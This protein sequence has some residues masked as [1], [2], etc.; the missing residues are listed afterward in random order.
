MN[1]KILIFSKETR[2]GMETFFR[3]LN[4]L[5]NKNYDINFYFFKKDLLANYKGLTKTFINSNFPRDLGFTLEKVVIF[6]KN[7]YKSFNVIKNSEPD[8]IFAADIYS[9][10]IIS[11]VKI[12]SDKPFCFVYLINNNYE[13]ILRYKRERFYGFII[14]N[15][16]KFF[17]SVPDKIIFTSKDLAL[18]L[19]KFFNIDFK[20]ALIINHSTDIQKIEKLKEEDI[21]SS[22]KLIMRNKKY[23]KVFYTGRL[24]IFQKDILT[25]IKAF[26]LLHKTKKNARLFFVADGYEVEDIKIAV[27]ARE[28]EKY[29]FFLGWKKNVYKYLKYADIFWFSSFFEGFGMTIVEAMACKVPVVAT[30]SPFGPSEI[31]G[32]GKYGIL[33]PVDDYQALAKESIKLIEDKTLRRKYSKLGYIR[34]RKYSTGEMLKKYNKLFMSLTKS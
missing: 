19:S 26:D 5:K 24:D 25:I 11:I 4:F 28:L 2:G 17:A 16:F 23:I 14:I 30:A 33:V 10:N 9:F 22:D 34:S 1:K 32:R 15:L 29:T 13:Y 3:Q 8:I 12:L 31:L 27:H 7:I 20:K 18:N 6:F 21:S